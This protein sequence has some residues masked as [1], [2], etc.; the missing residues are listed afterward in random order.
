MQEIPQAALDYFGTIVGL[1]EVSKDANRDETL[2]H[3]LA[4][5]IA[6]GTISFKYPVAGFAILGTGGFL[7]A[8][9]QLL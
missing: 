6:G 8:L 9:A 1:F 3:F 2:T 4:I 5:A 7:Y